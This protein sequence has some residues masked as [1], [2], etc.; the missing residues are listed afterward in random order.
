MASGAKGRLEHFDMAGEGMHRDMMEICLRAKKMILNT[1]WL[2]WLSCPE[3][4]ADMV[5]DAA[6]PGYCFG[7][8]SH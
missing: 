8:H 2:R 5:D 4:L 6:V 7:I 3:N 1:N